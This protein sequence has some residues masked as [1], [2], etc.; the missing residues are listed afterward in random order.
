MFSRFARTMNIVM[1]IL[2]LV[3]CTP[4]TTVAPPTTP[5]PSIPTSTP[6]PIAP[7]RV[8]FQTEDGVSIAGTL[9]GNGENAVILAHQGTPGADQFT[10]TQ[11]AMTLAENGF[12]ALTF[13]FRGVGRS[14]GELDQSKL[15]KDV[16]AAARYLQNQGYHQIVCA[17]ASMG[18]TACLRAAIDGEPFLGLITL[19]ST[20]VLF[21][22]T[23]VILP[24]ELGVLTQPKLF[25]TAENDIDLVVRDTK[26]MYRLSPEP[27]KLLL[28]EGYEH[29]TDL[30]R[31]RVGDE[32]RKAML[33]FLEEVFT[34]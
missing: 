23:M 12:T 9:Y 19:A 32:L 21:H 28:L 18:G 33:D 2:L 17:G 8:T 26:S 11:F 4:A 13:D 1:G 24:E 29:G 10:W 27:K 31:T 3:S 16:R 6:T 15:D 14:G 30:F 34:N 20:L 7:Q 25:I 22:R 5:T